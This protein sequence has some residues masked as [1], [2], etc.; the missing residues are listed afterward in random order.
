MAQGSPPAPPHEQLKDEARAWF[1]ALRDE[2]CRTF[3]AIEDEQDGPLADR[4]PGRFERTAWQRPT[5]SGG[6][7]DERSGGGGGGVMSVMRGRV[8]EKV[9]VNVSTVSGEFSPE[10]RKSIPGAE[11][12]PRF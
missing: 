1:E 9:G 11:E 2:I 10:F 3:E 4:A 8:F 6:S 5:E 12:D 7:P